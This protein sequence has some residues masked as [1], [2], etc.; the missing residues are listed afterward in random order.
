M[1]GER[2]QVI[3]QRLLARLGC[4]DDLTVWR[5]NTGMLHDANGAV[6]RFGLRGSADI[7]GIADPGLFVAI[8]V[9]RLGGK[10]RP[11]QAAFAAMV[12]RH[13]GIYLMITD[14][15]AGVTA[16]EVALSARRARTV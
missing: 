3:Q 8:E 2:E 13:G 12:Q 7:L 9:K 6:V 16:L 5:N 1:V 10:L 14:V 11:Q 15:D 4:R